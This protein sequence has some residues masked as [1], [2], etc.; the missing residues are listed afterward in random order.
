MWAEQ[1]KSYNGNTIALH[2]KIQDKFNFFAEHAF[3]WKLDF[4][5]TKTELQLSFPLF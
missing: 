2:D 3:L 5:K 4:I 1:I